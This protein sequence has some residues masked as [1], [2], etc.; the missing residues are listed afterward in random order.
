MTPTREEAARRLQRVLVVEDDLTSREFLRCA[1]ERNGWVVAAADGVLAAQHELLASGFEAFDCVVT[2]YEMPEM[3]G[4]D[5]LAWL[6]EW[7]AC[8][9]TIMLTSVGEK[10]LVAESLRGGAVDFLEK[11]V[12]IEKLLEAILSASARTKR[13]RHSSAVQLSVKELGQ[14]QARLLEVHAADLPVQADICFHPKLEAGG[15]FFSHFQPSP[16]KYCCLLTDVSGHDLQAAYLSAYFQGIVRG[17]LERSA[18]LPEV[19]MYFNRLLLEEW[20]GLRRSDAGTSTAV[21]A[22]LMDFQQQTVNVITCGTP[23]PVFVA[24]DGRARM[25]TEQGGSPLGWFADCPV[26]SSVQPAAEGG[27]FLLWTDGLEDLAEKHRVSALSMGLVLQRAR[28]SL[29]PP[30]EVAAAADDILFA[31]VRVPARG[32]EP[33]RWQ[34]LLLEEYHGGQGGEIDQLQARWSDSVKRAVPEAPGELI[35]NLLLASREA[36]LNA[37]KHGCQND[38]ERRTMFQISCQPASQ[39]FRVWVD[40]PGPGHEF[41]LTAHEQA[42]TQQM[43]EEHRGMILMKRLCRT[44]AF[45]RNGASVIMDF[46]LEPTSG[47]PTVP[48]EPRGSFTTQEASMQP[49]SAIKSSIRAESQ[50]EVLSLVIAGDLTSAHIKEFHSAIETALTV[51][52]GEAAPWKIVALHLPNAS[53]VD[54][55]GLNLIV[56]IYKAA[57]QA[58]ARMQVVYTNPNVH[59]TLLFTRL[60]RQVELIKV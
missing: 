9:A 13:E 60:D 39:T 21:C 34:P 18:P 22:L 11:P 28:A 38:A 55:M 5:L 40:D 10:Q 19:F 54:S 8:L 25:L 37:L 14:T 1:L 47:A 53:M 59:R 50:Q 33:D 51:P 43:V 57:L 31:E 35:Y 15:D 52:A 26:A 2:D 48:P 32:P 44:L 20:S 29:L 42:T 46:E 12:D 56:K 4:L 23:A 3:T 41:D 24:P 30:R 7:D 36:V 58:G 16:E 27:S 45:E 17:M 6:K 49:S